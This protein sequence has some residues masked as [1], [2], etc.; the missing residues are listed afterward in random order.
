MTSYPVQG[1]GLGLRRDFLDQALA[2]PPDR[3]AFW[4]LAPEN[5]EHFSREPPC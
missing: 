3:V 1:A 4:E 5:S 2:L